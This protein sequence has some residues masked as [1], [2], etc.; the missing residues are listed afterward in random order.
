MRHTSSATPL[1]NPHPLSEHLSSLA[2]R[3][4]TQ[5]FILSHVV[6]N[7]FSIACLSWA[8]AKLGVYISLMTSAPLASGFTA[9]VP[10]DPNI[11]GLKHAVDTE[12]V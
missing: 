9:S 3:L 8:S 5:S 6:F 4:N 2:Q 7:L 12:S 10:S 1:I 11:F